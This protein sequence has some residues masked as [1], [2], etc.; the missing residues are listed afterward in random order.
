MDKITSQKYFDNILIRR[1]PFKNIAVNFN[2]VKLSQI[3]SLLK[4]FKDHV[5]FLEIKALVMKNFEDCYGLF[6]GMQNL[7]NL[8]MQDCKLRILNG[9]ALPL[10]ETLQVVSFDKCDENI[11]KIFR[12]QQ[13]LEKIVVCND[14][15]TWNGFC[16]E[17]FNNLVKNLPKIRWVVMIGSGTGSYFDC[18]DFPY[19][20]EVLEATMITFHWYVGIKTARINFLKTQLGHLKE[21]T[22][23]QLPFDFDGGKVLKYIIEE[24]NLDK[25]YYGKIPLI[26][27]GYK[28]EVKEFEAS[29]IQIQS[30]FEMF[31][32]FPCK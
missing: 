5:Q 31:R 12:N 19:F 21:L 30:A 9:E 8:L 13:S 16:H 4:N 1:I 27:D 6:F 3:L 17:S 23:H 2:S 15:H 32:Q 10:I 25:F 22:I 24:M 11:F 26:V 7:T 28:Q 14:V 20:I 29:E 18:D